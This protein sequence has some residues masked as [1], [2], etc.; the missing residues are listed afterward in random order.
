MALPTYDRLNVEDFA[1]SKRPLAAE[2]LMQWDVRL[3][4]IPPPDNID[5]ELLSM[6][7]YMFVTGYIAGRQV[8]R[9]AAHRAGQVA[10]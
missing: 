10:L 3:A 8:G 4:E 1:K 7:H 9:M 2:A 6:A 5:T